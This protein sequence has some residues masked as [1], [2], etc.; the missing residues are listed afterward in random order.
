MPCPLDEESF[1]Q[2][3]PLLAACQDYASH[4]RCCFR[5]SDFTQLEVDMT[6]LQNLQDDDELFD[7][8]QA[9]VVVTHFSQHLKVAMW[10]ASN[11]MATLQ[12]QA[13]MDD[14]R[15]AYRT[16]VGENVRKMMITTCTGLSMFPPTE[17]LTDIDSHDCSYED[18]YSPF[19]VIAQR[20]YNEDQMRQRHGKRRWQRL[21]QTAS[22]ILDFAQEVG[23]AVPETSEAYQAVLAEFQLRCLEWQDETDESCSS[24]GYEESAQGSI[25]PELPMDLQ[26]QVDFSKEMQKC[27]NALPHIW[28]QIFGTVATFAIAATQQEIAA[29]QGS[30]ETLENDQ[31]KDVSISELDTNLNKLTISEYAENLDMAWY[32]VAHHY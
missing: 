10:A 14:L 20:L 31:R 23:V 3:A 18:V 5:S 15:Q 16:V 13:L 19:P 28:Q 22:F 12:Q 7:R 1:P 29:G 9:A 6:S 4:S 32:D 17:S 21:E 11:D 26:V 27:L 24:E 30:R 2:F 25:D 8:R